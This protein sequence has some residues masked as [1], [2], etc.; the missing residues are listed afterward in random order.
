MYDCQKL[1]DAGIAL[2]G[3]FSKSFPCGSTV[4]LSSS[5]ARAGCHDKSSAHGAFAF[6]PQSSSGSSQTSSG[7]NH[8]SLGS[9][10]TP[11]LMGG[12]VVA[13]TGGGDARREASSKSTLGRVAPQH[14][15]KRL[16][17]LWTLANGS[18]N[19]H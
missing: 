19:E 18:S 17:Q 8:N 10:S 4:V 12:V 1:G 11:K 7:S 16:F 3:L 15:A 2:V 5:A 9:S 13:R 14:L 6:W